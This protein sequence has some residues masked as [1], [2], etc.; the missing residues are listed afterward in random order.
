MMEE[1]KTGCQLTVLCHSF[2]AYWP[3][4]VLLILLFGKE[5]PKVIPIVLRD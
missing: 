3:P 1:H 2:S 5:F 4:W